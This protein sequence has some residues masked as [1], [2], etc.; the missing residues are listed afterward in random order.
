LIERGVLMRKSVLALFVS[1]ALL[2]CGADNAMHTSP[3]YALTLNAGP[4]GKLAAD[5]A[6][7][8]YAP[9][10]LVNLTA[11]PDAQFTVQAWSGTDDDRSTQPTN[12]VTMSA[13]RTVTVQF[14]AQACPVDPATGHV[15]A[16]M[17]SPANGATLP[18]GAVTFR[19]CNANADY[20]LTIESV[21]GAH[22]IFFAFAG[23][24]GAGVNTL[25]LGPGC[26]AAPPTGCVLPRGES[27]FVTLFTLKQGNIVSRSPFHYTYTAASSAP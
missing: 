19:W 23:G 13:D 3:A 18:A 15:V 2:G 4:N 16:R 26:A 5:P 25:T 8:T 9:R 7:P 21:M 12:H 24:P 1:C 10:T 22:D 17:I 14:A 27:I 20:F 6:G 11:T